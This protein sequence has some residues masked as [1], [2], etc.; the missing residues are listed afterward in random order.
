MQVIQVLLA[1]GASA[2][3]ADEDGQTPLQYATLCEHKQV[4]AILLLMLLASAAIAG[5]MCQC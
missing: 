1:H 5:A 3:A 4:L 2:N